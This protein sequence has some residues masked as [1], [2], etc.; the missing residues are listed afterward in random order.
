MRRLGVYGDKLPTK[1]DRSVTP[2]DFSI[3]GMYGRFPRKF[4]VPFR[5]RN[6]QEAMTVLGPQEDPSAYGWDALNGFFANLGG[7]QGS[8]YVASYKGTG[9]VQAS[10]SLPDTQ[11]S[12]ESTLKLSAAYQG[13]AE[14][15]ASGKRTGFTLVG[16]A[17]TSSGV[18][19]LPTGG[20]PR[21]AVL[22][23]VVG[24]RVGDVVRMHSSSHDEYHFVTAIDESA[25]SISWGDTDYSGSGV[26]AD[27]VLEVRGFQVK[28][29]RKDTKGVVSEVD[30][31]I[32]K[33]WCTMNSADPDRY[34]ES[35]FAQSS[36]LSASNLAVTGSPAA[37]KALPA[38][39]TDVTFLES[40]ADGTLPASASDWQAVYAL[41]NN[42]PVRWLA[43]VETSNSDYQVALLEYCNARADRPIAVLVG[44]YGLSTKQAVL[45]AAQPF[46]ASDESD[47]VYIHNW[48]GVPDPFATSGSAPRRAVPNAG[49]VMG[50]WI[51]GIA[52]V[53]VHAIPARRSMPLN[54]ASEAYGYDAADDFDRTDLADSGVN[55]IQYMDGAGLVVRNLFTVSSDAAFRY[56]NA[57]L[58][59]NYVRESIVGSLRDSENTPN[60]IAHVREDRMAALQFM[61]RL[62]MYGSTGNVPEGETFGRYELDDGS[63]SSKDDAFEVVG[64][65]SNNSVATL[66]EGNRNLD[67]WFMFPAPAGSIRVG[68]GLIYK[69]Q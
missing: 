18:T 42:L 34:V 48:L 5:F 59:R 45:L 22:Y 11:T 49:H 3:A 66:Q 31:A 25:K 62:W 35:V 64:D 20:S 65:A 15:G 6:T 55:V 43:N 68:V 16:G 41:M 28:T 24:I 63:M 2:A 57:V 33:L 46:Q 17:I 14:Y 7:N 69:V 53:G 67:V 38:D 8:I 21:T 9:A 29:Y 27:Y 60:D 19:T 13:N 26:A 23:S 51:S 58:E 12:P 50:W 1:K 47:G 32:G 54:G 10:K 39:V 40:G 4:D 56:S 61:N 52:S 44:Q 36:W 30:A 37:D